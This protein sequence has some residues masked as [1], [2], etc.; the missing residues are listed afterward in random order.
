[1]GVPEPEK[2]I[3]LHFPPTAPTGRIYDAVT[4]LRLPFF[5]RSTEELVCT[6]TLHSYP[7]SLPERPGRLVLLPGGLP[8]Q[9]G[10]LTAAILPLERVRKVVIVCTYRGWPVPWHSDL[11]LEDYHYL[12]QWEAESWGRLL[13]AI[14]ERGCESLEVQASNN[15]ASYFTSFYSSPFSWLYSTTATR[16]R[17]ALGHLKLLKQDDPD[18]MASVLGKYGRYRY[19]PRLSN[20]ETSPLFQ[21]EPVN[22]K[23]VALSLISEGARKNTKLRHLTM[24]STTSH[25]VN[26]PSLLHPPLVQWT[27]SALLASSIQSLSIA[28]LNIWYLLFDASLYLLAQSTA[29]NLQKLELGVVSARGNLENLTR[30]L[31]SFQNLTTLTIHQLMVPRLQDVDET[32]HACPT[33]PRLLELSVPD[34]WFKHTFYTHG[35]SHHFPKLERLTVVLR[36]HYEG[37]MSSTEDTLWGELDGLLVPKS[38]LPFPITLKVYTPVLSLQWLRRC[39]QAMGDWGG[40]IASLVIVVDKGLMSEYGGWIKSTYVAEA[41][42]NWVKGLVNLRSV[43]IVTEQEELGFMTEALVGWVKQTVGERLDQFIVDGVAKK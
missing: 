3:A 29:Q 40:R 30:W 24:G 42:Q 9:V 35:H 18:S 6:L 26:H 1:M 13:N 25:I 4:A 20:C 14:L 39:Q 23:P 31:N 33:L 19:K 7:S 37:S 28:N 10:R 8:D 36:P 43:H 34:L 41:F 21:F 22:R 27:Y 32:K 11:D 15:E 38:T 17:S 12:L 2:R 16:V 5:V